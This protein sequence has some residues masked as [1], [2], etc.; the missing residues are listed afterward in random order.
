MNVNIFISLISRANNAVTEKAA[1]TVSA[2]H[3]IR[4]E[5]PLVTSARPVARRGSCY[6]PRCLHRQWHGP[7]VTAFSFKI[8][9]FRLDHDD[10][11][12]RDSEYFSLAAGQTEGRPGSRRFR[13]SR[14][15]V[16]LRNLKD[17]PPG[18]DASSFFQ[19][20]IQVHLAPDAMI[21]VST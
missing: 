19:V 5:R 15:T 3:S 9:C 11:R 6:G 2:E 8:K 14:H 1:E 4:L 7:S 10:V 21:L 17:G 12:V 18:V 16:G 13:L 20:A